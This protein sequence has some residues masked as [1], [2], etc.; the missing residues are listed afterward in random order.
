[1]AVKKTLG[2]NNKKNDENMANKPPLR[3]HSRVKQLAYFA[4]FAARSRLNKN[5][6]KPLLCSFKLTGN[7]NLKCLHCPFWKT[8]KP[9]D[10][11]YFE[12]TSMLQMLYMDGVRIVI[13]EGGEPLLWKDR[14]NNKD[15]GD[16]ICYA[17][18][19]FFCTGVTTNG[20]INLEKF[21]P[22]IFFIS[23]D[24]LEE[25]HDRIR[26]KSFKKIIENLEKNLRSKKIITN[27]CISKANYNELEET[28]KFLNNRV[29]GTTIQFFYPYEGL[30][31]DLRLSNS[32]KDE[33]LKKLLGL[34]KQG[35]KIL[36][37]A[38][39]LKRIAHNTWRCSDFLVSSVEQDGTVSYG[40][41]LKNKVDNVLCSEC[42]FAVHC[43]I[44]LAYNLDIDAL[45][46]AKVVFWDS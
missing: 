37:S 31:D 8:E 26:G 39:C 29:Y 14:K 19:L 4:A 13:F 33:V 30:D 3:R 45:K 11:N 9:A 36:D 16:V 21:G 23:I 25:T 32:E 20:T 38:S 27:I 12:V 7:C 35:Y 43:E 24:G 6:K 17:Q 28:I 18:K 1:M 46:T 5:Y 44:S 40:C 15:I 34:K 22:D 41:Y 2:I 10:M 42:G